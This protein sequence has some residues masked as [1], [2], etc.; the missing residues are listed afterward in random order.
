MFHYAIDYKYSGL[1]KNAYIFDFLYIVMSQI[2]LC[3]F[4]W[5]YY[6]IYAH[7]L[8]HLADR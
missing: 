7:I 4:L 1:F 8:E 6:K 2:D 3:K 5:K